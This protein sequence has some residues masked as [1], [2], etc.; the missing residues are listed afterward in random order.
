MNQKDMM[1]Q[2][3]MDEYVPPTTQPTHLL[4]P[5][6]NNLQEHVKEHN[7]TTQEMMDN[8]R[9][10]GTQHLNNMKQKQMDFITGMG[11]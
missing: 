7:K 11:K 3:N 1:P 9:E 8:L 6:T 5:L 10:Q 4:E 2:I